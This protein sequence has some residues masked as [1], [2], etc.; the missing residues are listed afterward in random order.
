MYIDVIGTGYRVAANCHRTS[1]AEA[2]VLPPVL[3]MLRCSSGASDNAIPLK[4][5]GSFSRTNVFKTMV[6]RSRESK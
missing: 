3:R 5:H 4:I 6:Y 2:G 1:R